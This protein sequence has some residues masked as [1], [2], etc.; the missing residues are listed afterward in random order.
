MKDFK[1]IQNGQERAA[2]LSG[3]T[4]SR[5]TSAAGSTQVQFLI[6]FEVFEGDRWRPFSLVVTDQQMADL[7][8][9]QVNLLDDEQA[10]RSLVQVRYYESPEAVTELPVSGDDLEAAFG[11]L[12]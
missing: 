10:I 4:T 12:K 7:Q 1:L 3:V 8:D 9:R 6:P 5:K 11:N 2:R